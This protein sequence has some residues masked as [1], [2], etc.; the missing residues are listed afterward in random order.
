[1]VFFIALNAA[2][3]EDERNNNKQS[4]ARKKCIYK[5]NKRLF[6]VNFE[7]YGRKK[8]KQLNYRVTSNAMGLGL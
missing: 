4:Y 3:K 5:H 1:M 8:Q 2:K 6:W 7:L